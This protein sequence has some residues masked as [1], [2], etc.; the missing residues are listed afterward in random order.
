[1]L[2]VALAFASGLMSGL[3]LGSGLVLGVALAF[4]SAL[5]S[6]LGLGSGFMTV[7]LQSPSTLY[8]LSYSRSVVAALTVDNTC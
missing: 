2:G 3:G 8:G 7:M 1:M 5:V 6:G 4:A